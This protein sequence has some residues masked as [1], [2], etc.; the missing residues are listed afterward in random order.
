MS[1][2]VLDGIYLGV[3]LGEF[4]VN[5]ILPEHLS[6]QSICNDIVSI[7]RAKSFYRHGMYFVG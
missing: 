3:G 2:I 1:H 5:K 6:D 4:F 7:S